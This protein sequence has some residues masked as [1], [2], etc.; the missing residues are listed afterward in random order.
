MTKIKHLNKSNFSSQIKELRN[1][2]FDMQKTFVSNNTEK[3]I[4]DW[5]EKNTCQFLI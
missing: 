5:E 2:H 1:E 4:F 3:Y